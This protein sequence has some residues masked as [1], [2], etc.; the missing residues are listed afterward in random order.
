MQMKL[1]LIPIPVADVDR[2]KEFYAEKLGFTVDPDQR[3]GENFRVVQRT[4]PGSAW[5]LWTRP[6]VRCS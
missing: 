2:A 6:R 5:E 4:S 3:F 1:E